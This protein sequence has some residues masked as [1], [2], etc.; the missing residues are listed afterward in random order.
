MGRGDLA[1]RGSE[2]RRGAAAD[3][4]RGVSIARTHAGRCKALN[5]QVA[6]ARRLPGWSCGDLKK[7]TLTRFHCAARS[8]IGGATN[9]MSTGHY[10]RLF[11]LMPEGGTGSGGGGAGGRGRW[12]YFPLRQ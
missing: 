2:T 10:M 11:R 8:R 6:T 3:K 5:G 4:E 9:W 12:V 7:F 1:D